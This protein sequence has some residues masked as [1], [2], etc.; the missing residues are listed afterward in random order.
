MNEIESWLTRIANNLNGRGGTEQALKGCQKTNGLSVNGIAG[1]VTFGAMG[2][3]QLVQLKRGTRGDADGI[4]G[5]L[6]LAAMNIGGA[7]TGP[8]S[9]GSLRKAAS[10]TDDGGIWVAV[11]EI[12]AGASDKIKSI[13][14]F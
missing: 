13:F 2:L 1:P 10:A 4:A 14:S 11:E 12:A 9:R 8:D 6:T 5:Q 7:V 3:H